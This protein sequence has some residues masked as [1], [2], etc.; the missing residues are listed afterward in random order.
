M[1][2]LNPQYAESLLGMPE[3]LQIVG[4]GMLIGGISIRQI[5]RLDN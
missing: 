4:L 5:I 3:L 1:M 2:V